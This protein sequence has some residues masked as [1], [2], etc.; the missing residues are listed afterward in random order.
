MSRAVEEGRH[1]TEIYP[2]NVIRNH[3]LVITSSP[4]GG[5]D[6]EMSRLTD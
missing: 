6:V 1:A 3:A 5:G 4:I 2:K